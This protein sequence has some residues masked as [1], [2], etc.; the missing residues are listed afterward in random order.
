MPT[1]PSST[2]TIR[3]SASSR[4]TSTPPPTTRATSP[5]RSAGTG[6][7]SSSDGIRRDIASREDLRAAAARVRHRARTRPSSSTATTTTGSPPGRTGS[8]SCSGSGERQDPQR[9]PQVLGRQGPARAP[10]TRRRYAADRDQPRRTPTSATARSATT[11]SSRSTAGG[12]LVDV[13]SPGR[14]SAASSSRP[15]RCPQEGAQRGGHIPGAASIPWAQAVNE[16]GTFKSRRR[17]PRR[18]TARRASPPDK[19]VIAYCRIGERSSHTWFV[20]HELLG[21]TDVR[22][23]DGSWTEWGSLV[24][25]PIEKSVPALVS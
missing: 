21:F 24:G 25:V 4:S 13:R 11:C 6:R 22:N 16:D 12:A 2:S 20:L 10:P 23:Y 19:D 14:V 9:R 5:A 3:T 8:S 18:S 17:A 15:R 7:A 1:G